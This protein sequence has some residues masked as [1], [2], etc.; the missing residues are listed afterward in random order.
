MCA[1]LIHYSKPHQHVLHIFPNLSSSRFQASWHW[2]RRNIH[3]ADVYSLQWRHMMGA[4]APRLPATPLFVQ[5]F[6]Q[7]NYKGHIK[8]PHH[9]P[10][11]RVIHRWTMDS[12]HKG[13]AVESVSMQWWHHVDGLV[14]E[15]RNSIANALDLRLSCTNPSMFPNLPPGRVRTS[16]HWLR[17]NI[18]KA[19]VYC[20]S[21]C[22]SNVLFYFFSGAGPFAPLSCSAGCLP[23]WSR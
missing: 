19:D 12:P 4:M 7:S 11:V 9:W 13:P 16:R 23:H 20:P 2:P 15:R 8:A 1:T 5:Q 21:G 3:K 18:H 22:L 14:Q 10:F 17:R 6:D